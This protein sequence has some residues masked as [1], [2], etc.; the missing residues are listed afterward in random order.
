MSSEAIASRRSRTRQKHDPKHVAAARELRDRFL[1]QV[2][3]GLLLP[4][5]GCEA[6]YDASRQLEVADA[7]KVDA[8]P[9][10]LLDG[11]GSGD[12]MAT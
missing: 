5:G 4:G 8:E 12:T 10:A 3:R 7:D 11:P 9:Q 1:E 6:K 2:D